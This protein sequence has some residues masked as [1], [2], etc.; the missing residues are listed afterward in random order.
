MLSPYLKKGKIL[1]FLFSFLS[2]SV[3][4]AQSSDLILIEQSLENKDQIL[5]KLPEDAKILLVASDQNGWTLL[6]EYLYQNP[7]TE[8]IHLFAKIQGQELILG[9][10]RYN[11]T[12]LEA[13]PEMAMLEGAY[14]TAPFK[15]LIYHCSANLTHP[16]QALISP[17][18]NIGAFDVGLSTQCNDMVSDNFI[19]GPTSRSKSTV[20]SILN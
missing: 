20:N 12:S 3:I 11:K 10:N 2:F 9:Q 19:F 4:H 15:L 6:R 7:N 16:L 17:L 1:F 14:Q 8:Q 18:S 5:S 13:E